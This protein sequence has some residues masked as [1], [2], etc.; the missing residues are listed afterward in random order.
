MIGTYWTANHTM[1]PKEI[2][3]VKILDNLIIT[4]D[5][6]DRETGVMDKLEV[7][8]KGI[9]HRAFSLFVVNSDGQLL[10]QKRA[11]I[12]YHSGGLWSNSCCS[13]GV[14][15]EPLDTT[16]HV[17]LYFEM[18]FDCPVKKLF[19]FRYETQFDNGL[20]ENEIDHVYVGHYNGDPEPDPN[21]VDDWGWADIKKLIQDIGNNPE[22]YT[23][24]FRTALPQFIE[25]LR[26]KI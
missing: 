8:K 13:H 11:A 26:K 16:V 2:E 14:S 17:R 4:V 5:D 20:V 12:K 9:L 24:W 23:Y 1:T 25:E 6:N 15:G 18:G 21:E 22:R 7:H 3:G 19:T 10:L